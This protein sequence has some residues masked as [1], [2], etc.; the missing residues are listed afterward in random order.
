[1][2]HIDRALTAV[3]HEAIAIA[4]VRETSRV[5]TD[6][7]RPTVA[8]VVIDLVLDERGAAAARWAQKFAAD[9]GVPIIVWV[10]VDNQSAER[11]I[12][13][14]RAFEAETAAAARYW[15]G[16]RDIVVDELRIASG[17]PG[18]DLV[19]S[20]EEGDTVVLGVDSTEGFSPWALGSH[21]HELVHGLRCPLIIVPP[22][23]SSSESAPIIVGV[24]GTDANCRVL[25]W[26]TMLAGALRRELVPVFAY[27]TLAVHDDATG[28]HSVLAEVPGRPA[29]VLTAVSLDTAAYL[30]VVGARSEHSLRGLL[31]GR[32]V[33][34]LLHHAPRPVAIV[35]RNE[36]HTQNNG[37]EVN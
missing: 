28:E 22:A 15:L 10:M 16:A 35:A 17:A 19:A 12:E 25:E 7:D 4:H 33:D 26:A 3:D 13:I 32:V 14:E 30:T 24:D 8:R 37:S 1:M 11:S 5:S 20:V 21:A 9:L 2:Q 34:Q 27:D 36:V 31:V 29:R 6:D 23:E 18:A